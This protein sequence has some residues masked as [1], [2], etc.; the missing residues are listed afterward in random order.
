MEKEIDL[1]LKFSTL[2]L[3]FME[4]VPIEK[5]IRFRVKKVNNELQ[6]C[7]IYYKNISRIL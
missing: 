6:K 5:S 7:K 4:A 1:I 2:P 3:F